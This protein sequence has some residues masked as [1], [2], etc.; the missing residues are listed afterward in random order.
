MQALV[1]QS[2]ICSSK[3]FRIFLTEKNP[4]YDTP[5]RPL[6]S[7]IAQSLQQIP[8]SEV[9]SQGSP[10]TTSKSIFEKIFAASPP[11]SKKD[12]LS[13][14]TT[15]LSTPQ[16]SNSLT[17]PLRSSTVSNASTGQIVSATEAVIDF[18]IEIFELK[19]KNNWWR[20]QAIVLILQQLFGGTVER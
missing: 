17:N 8:G 16:V 2:E 19:E 14:S 6:P 20:K 12:S 10:P 15:R 11:K 1:Q 7:L 18:F 3:E 5:K 13:S 9:L 4:N